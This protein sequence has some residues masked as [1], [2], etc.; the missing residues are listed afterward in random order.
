MS[1]YIGTSFVNIKPVL[2]KILSVTS[3]D[4]PQNVEVIQMKNSYFIINHNDEK[5]EV[6]LDNILE[7]ILLAAYE[8]R[9]IQMNLT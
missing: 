1:Y 7:P 6:H 5:K 8:Y 3:I 4:S 9:I 2:D